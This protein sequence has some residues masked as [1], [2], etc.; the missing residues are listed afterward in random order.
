MKVAQSLVYQ[1][2]YK[3]QWF[4]ERRTLLPQTP[5]YFW[6]IKS[7][8]VRTGTWLEDGTMITLGLW[9]STEI[10]GISLTRLDPYH[11]EC[12]TPVEAI[13][14]PITETHQLNTILLLQMQQ[15]EELAVIRAHRKIDS[16][17]LKLLSWLAQKFGRKA[18]TGQLIDL[19]L[20]HQDLA[21]LLGATRVTITRTLNQLEQQGLIERLPL[22]RI[23]LRE[24]DT[25]HYQI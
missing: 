21:D 19:R 2:E 9:G 20:T 8:V 12:L 24:E 7:G 5:N 1:L 23:I 4:F 11:I 25:W 15:L 13:A 14:I 3:K 22:H 10:V 16:M 18:A 17:L 6:K